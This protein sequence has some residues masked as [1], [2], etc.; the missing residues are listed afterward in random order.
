METEHITVCVCTYRRMH[1]LPGLFESIG[2]QK[3]D[4]R[5]QVSVAVVDND[6]GTAEPLVSELCNKYAIPLSFEV[7]NEKNLALVRNRVVK[8]A[9]SELLAFID[10]DEVPVQ[11]WLLRLRTSMEIYQAHGVLGPVRP[12]FDQSPP[13]WV[14]RGQLCERPSHPTGTIL[15]WSQTRTGNVLLRSDIFRKKGIWF[16][17]AYATGGEDTDFFKRA[18][19][20]GAKFVWCE[21]GPVYELVPSERLKRRY[22]LKRAL[23]QGSISLKFYKGTGMLGL[24]LVALKTI[25]AAATYFLLLPFFY[26][27]GEHVLM[28]YL[29][30]LCH[31]LGRIRAFAGSE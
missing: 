5:F 2:R 14:I 13:Q 25:V 18:I 31:H 17:P 30:K 23:T 16:D 29:I 15:H 26:V 21:E 12:S 24:L 6:G 19:C 1:L 22:F 27:R 20:T 7:E 3:T 9:K 4:G 8:L 28:K 11:D 10:D